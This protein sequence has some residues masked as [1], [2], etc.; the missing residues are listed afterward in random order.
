MHEAPVN[1]PSHNPRVHRLG[2]QGYEVLCLQESGLQQ[3]AEGAEGG[4][5]ERGEGCAGLYADDGVVGDFL[6]I[7]PLF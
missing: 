2:L 5:E 1:S 3:S 4:G 6:Y 7:S